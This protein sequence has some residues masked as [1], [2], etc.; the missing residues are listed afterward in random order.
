MGASSG[1]DVWQRSQRMGVTDGVPLQ[2]RQALAVIGSK[3]PGNSW[4]AAKPLQHRGRDD[5]ASSQRRDQTSAYSASLDAMV[6]A[7]V[8]DYGR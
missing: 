2:L 3:F 5:S 7:H 1:T 8:I 4:N 6:V